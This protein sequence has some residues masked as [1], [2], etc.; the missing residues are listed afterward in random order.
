MLLISGAIIVIVSVFGGYMALGGKILVLWQPFEVVIICGAAIGAYIIANPK[1][2]LS[3]IGSAVGQII[4][5]P[6]CHRQGSL[7]GQL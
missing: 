1:S 6:R 5:G 4:K 2:V 3:K 7:R